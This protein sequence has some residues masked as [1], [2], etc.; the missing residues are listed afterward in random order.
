MLHFFHYVHLS[1][2][3]FYT[4]MFMVGIVSERYVS[5]CF[6]IYSVITLW[7]LI[8]YLLSTNKQIAYFISGLFAT[9]G[10]LCLQKYQSNWQ[11]IASSV[12]GH[13][14][15]VIGIITN[16]VPSLNSKHTVQYTLYV[17]KASEA[18]LQNTYLA[19]YVKNDKRLFNPGTKICIKNTLCSLAPPHFADYLMKEGLSATLYSSTKNIRILHDKK[20]L[21]NNLYTTR[22]ALLKWSGRL[23]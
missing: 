5:Q 8:F 11:H 1:P 14:I 21:W 19:L 3:T 18:I 9:T 10:A 22:L 16:R 23:L 15:T 12:A 6:V 7:L 2:F 4:A 13:N 17:T 20:S